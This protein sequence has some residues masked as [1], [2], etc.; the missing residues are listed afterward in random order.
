MSS[1]SSLSQL[2]NPLYLQDYI[3]TIGDRVFVDNGSS[4]NPTNSN[5]LKLG[6]IHASKSKRVVVTLIN[7]FQSQST[8]CLVSA[9][10]FLPNIIS[11]KRVS[12]IALCR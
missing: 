3:G 7:E 4:I 1:S 2:G 6:D 9:L 11:L 8:P 12:S 10:R 5:I